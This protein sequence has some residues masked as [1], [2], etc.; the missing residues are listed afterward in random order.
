MKTAAIQTAAILAWLTITAVASPRYY[1]NT[2]ISKPMAPTALKEQWRAGFNLGTGVGFTLSPRLEV[3]GGLSLHQMQLDDNAFLNTVT[4]A[5][6]VY[7]SVNGG[8]TTLL[9]LAADFKYLVPT[10]QNRQVTPYLSAAL[11]V[12]NKIVSQKEITTEERIYSEARESTIRALAGA[13]I[14]FEIAMAKNTSLAVEVGFRMMLT[15]EPTVVL[16]LNFGIVIN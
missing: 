13:G 5:N 2:G 11:G 1:V 15:K 9:G 6:D 3:I 14:G 16:P 8:T 4:K 12:A 7:A 10:A